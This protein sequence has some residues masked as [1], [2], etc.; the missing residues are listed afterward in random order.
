M[1]FCYRNPDVKPYM[2]RGPAKPLLL[3]HSKFQGEELATLYQ[4]GGRLKSGG[5]L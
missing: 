3:R 2:P 5:T 1:M 4:E